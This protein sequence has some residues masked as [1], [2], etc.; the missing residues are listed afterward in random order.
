M[1]STSTAVYC[2]RET[3]DITLGILLAITSN[4]RGRLC[5]HLLLGERSAP[6]EMRG[7]V[8]GEQLGDPL[9]FH[10]IT[11]KSND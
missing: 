3:G 6:S 10:V 9:G 7:G 1:L 11:W 2:E 8:E 5:I 4:P